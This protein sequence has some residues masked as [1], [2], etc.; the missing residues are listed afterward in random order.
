MRK[1]LMLLTLALLTQACTE[2]AFYE[3]SYSFKGNEWEQGIK[4]SFKVE[5]TDT[6]QVYDFMITLRNTTDYPYSNCWIYLNSLTPSKAKAR[7]PFEL[8]ITRPDGSWVGNKSGTIVENTLHFRQRK[9]PVA[10]TYYFKL[11]Q[12]V[13]QSSLPEV[14]DIGLRIEKAGVER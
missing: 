4:P 8:K 5:I 6:A 9:F 10:G 3:K 12:G 7:E 2:N 13:I 1:L 11:E 14:L